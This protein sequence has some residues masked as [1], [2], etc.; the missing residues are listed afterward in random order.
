M[1]NS[2][3]ILVFR[4][5]TVAKKN[6][7]IYLFHGTDS[8]SI[9]EKI[10]AWKA[11]F[12]EKYGSAGIAAFDCDECDM[13]ALKTALS[14]QTL[15]S[16]TSLVIAKNVF[17]KKAG[18]VQELL[19]ALLPNVSESTFIVLSDEKRDAKSELSKLLTQLAKK[20]VCALEEFVVP[21]GPVLKKWMSDRVEHYGGSFD[22]RALAV[23]CSALESRGYGDDESSPV[24]LWQLDNEIRKL[25]SFAANRAIT[26]DD[27]QSLACLPVSAHIFEL[28][29]ALVARNEKSA[30]MHAHRL[31]PLLRTLQFLMTQFRSFLILKSMEEDHQSEADMARV[32]GWN[33]KRV[34]VVNKKLA[35]HSTRSIKKA[36]TSLL[37]LERTMK[38]GAADPLLALDLFIT[39]SSSTR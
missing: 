9:A 20:G 35:A 19:C 16:S 32:L 7:H 21:Q 18:E 6:P 31:E 36:F 38:T 14:G 26:V 27:V 29:D 1:N 13:V 3:S 28:S 22:P 34:W 25:V 37:D 2:L 11:R 8:F 5:S 17:S 39:R 4:M 23:F 30:L 33:P 12:R 10:A 15:F 24:S